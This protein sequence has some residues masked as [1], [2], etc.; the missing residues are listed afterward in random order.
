M[1]TLKNLFVLIF[2]TSFANL[3]FGIATDLPTSAEVEFKG[4]VV[5]ASCQIDNAARTGA[6]A[7]NLPKVSLNSIADDTNMAGATPFTVDLLNCGGTEVALDL[8]AFADKVAGAP[9][10]NL[11]NSAAGA[12]VASGVSIKVEFASL[13]QGITTTPNTYTAIDFTQTNTKL[14]SY[15]VADTANQIRDKLYFRAGYVRT[16]AAV[17]PTVG[18]VKAGFTFNIVYQ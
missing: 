9:E 17:A 15:A 11:K 13:G 1:K 2:S 5:S 10:K 4:K 3:A 18:D 16:A 7:I 12:N 6:N 14:T 8:T